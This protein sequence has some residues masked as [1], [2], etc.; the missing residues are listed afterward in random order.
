MRVV[1]Q[2]FFPV[3]GTLFAIGALSIAAATKASAASAS[4]RCNMWADWQYCGYEIWFC[5]AL[6][7]SSYPAFRPPPIIT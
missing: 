7:C 2:Y 3:I 4:D 5:D 6:G 1:R